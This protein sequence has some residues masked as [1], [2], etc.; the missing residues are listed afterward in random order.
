MQLP[1]LLEQPLKYFILKNR[2]AFATGLVL[3]LITNAL[4]S[5]TPLVLKLAIDM[6]SAGNFGSQELLK[7][8]GLFFSL[9]LMLAATRYGWRIYWSTYHTS[10]ADELRN[11][12]FNHYSKMG[13]RFYTKNSVGELMSL[14]T[15]DVQFFRN[16]IGPGLLIL[17]DGISLILMILPAMIFLNPGWTGKSLLFI[18][19]VP[20]FIHYI[21]KK[22]G[23]LSKEQQNLLAQLT[24][25]TQELVSGVKIIKIFSMERQRSLKFQEI[26]DNYL[27]KSNQLNAVDSLFNPLMQLAVATGTMI[28]LYV[29]G[30]EVITGVATIGTFVAFQ[31]YI[32]KIIWP[33]SALGYGL[34]QMQKGRSAFER[35][36]S[37]LQEPVEFPELLSSTDSTE[38][39]NLVPVESLQLKNVSFQYGTQNVLQNINLEF[40][41]GE[42]VGIVGPVGS[43][44][45]TLLHLIV[46]YLG[47]YTG[48]VLING[49]NY[50]QF[51]NSD[52]WKTVKLVPQEPFL[53]SATIKENMILSSSA[54]MEATNRIISMID[55]EKDLSSLDQGLNTAV[56]E[57]GVQ[58]SGGQ[59]QR[60]A[61]ARGIFSSPQVILLDDT[62]SALDSKT[63]LNVRTHLF[64]SNSHQIRI[65][66]ANKVQSLMNADKIVVLSNGQIE[67]QGTHSELLQ[68]SQFYR[69]QWELQQMSGVESVGV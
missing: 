30:G 34:S 19:F 58:L 54:E 57:K 25:F 32:N 65:V 26:S 11:K 69:T 12:I 61:L 47:S 17:I 48:E 31:R 37:L 28:L 3:L 59:K 10:A 16:G 24:S 67:A 44:K 36:K 1:S 18:V 63:E 40:R 20:F 23:S 41:K 14:I 7:I 43:G 9:M 52:I 15:N 39:P 33:F 21:T 38:G 35:I 62:L 51:T 64:K 27:K 2:R 13:P 68:S 56:G 53:F 5:S 60:L 46:N 49:K 50:K 55:F 29:G 4:D 22:I 45:S 66:V 6:V 42:F 8:A